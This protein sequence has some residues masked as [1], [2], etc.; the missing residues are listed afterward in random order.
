MGQRANRGHRGRGK[1]LA[2]AVEAGAAT[3]P[4]TNKRL[5]DCAACP[6]DRRANWR[7]PKP[8]DGKSHYKG[9][10]ADAKCVRAQVEANPWAGWIMSAKSWEARW[11]QMD[12]HTAQ[13]VGYL[14]D[15]EQAWLE[16]NQPKG[17]T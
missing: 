9:K 12:M 11:D 13:A 2:L 6:L 10:L 8:I 4:K 17:S 5:Y 16:K 1:I 14:R 15:R 3:T 7:C